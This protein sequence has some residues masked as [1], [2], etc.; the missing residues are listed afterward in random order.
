MVTIEEIVKIFKYLILF[1]FLMSLGPILQAILEG[2]TLRWLPGLFREVGA[3]GTSMNI[4]TI[5]SLTLFILGGK[6]EYLY[7][8]IFFSFGVVMTILKKTMISNIVVWF[9][10]FTFQLERKAKIK[11][12]L[13]AIIFGV[14]S[15]IIFGD[16]LSENFQDNQQY[17]ENVGPEDHVRLGMYLASF[18]IVI[19]NFPFGSGLGTFG[20][21]ASIVNGYSSLYYEYNIDVIG[22]NSPEDVANGHHTLLDTFWPHI[23][24]EL[25]VFGFILFFFFWIYP[26][27]IAFKSYLISSEKITKALAFFSFLVVIT[28]TW[29]GITLYTPETPIFIMLN[30]GLVGMCYKHFKK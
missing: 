19:D 13:S 17:L 5:M 16:E 12:L 11:M 9:V 30:S 28:I 6:R 20:S 25:G 1:I 22:S 15:F 3:F 8:A 24:G 27:C 26:S 18:K 14:V 23:I 10:Y 7:L 2:S 4:A 29:E 21:L